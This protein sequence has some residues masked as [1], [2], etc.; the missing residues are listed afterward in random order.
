MSVRWMLCLQA[1]FT[2]NAA[3][4]AVNAADFAG[5]GGPADLGLAVFSGLLAVAVAIE[6]AV[7]R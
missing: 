2:V 5:A 4:A 1:L 3:S 6:L 7:N